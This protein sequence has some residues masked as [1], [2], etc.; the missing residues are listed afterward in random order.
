MKLLHF[1]EEEDHE[2][3]YNFLSESFTSKMDIISKILKAD[4]FFI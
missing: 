4:N 2:Y 3:L 1:K